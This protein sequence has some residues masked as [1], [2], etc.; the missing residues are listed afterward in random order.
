MYF[1]R[2]SHTVQLLLLLLA[3]AAPSGVATENVSISVSEPA[4]ILRPAYPVSAM[5]TLP[6]AAAEDSRFRL[7]DEDGSPI[8]AQFR[9]D[10]TRSSEHIFWLDFQTELKPYGSRKYT[11]QYGPDVEP[12]PERTSGHRLTETATEWRIENAPYLTWTIPR[13]LRSLIKSLSVPPVEFL[14][15]SS[16]GL[17]IVDRTGTPHPLADRTINTV[18]SRVVREGP[19]AV[20]LRFEITASTPALRGVR[21]TVDLHFPVS[22]SWVKVN[23]KLFDPNGMTKSQKVDLHLQLDRPSTDAPTL[24]DFGATTMVYTPLYPGHQAELH[25]TSTTGLRNRRS[26]SDSDEN[27]GQPTSRPRPRQRHHNQRPGPAWKVLRGPTD[28][29][30]PFFVGPWD[31]TKNAEGWAHAMDRRNCLALAISE[32]GR[33]TNDRISISAEGS[34]T[35]E[36]NAPGTS[37]S[38]NHVGA[39]QF[40]FW[41]HFVRFPPQQGAG[42]SPQAMQNPINVQVLYGR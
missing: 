12:G 31:G 9:S 5:F 10:R 7:V 16:P 35:L 39:K 36:R 26:E 34:V 24:V 14:Q 29:L 19:F 27:D 32:F 6:D 2:P 23:W 42:T 18:V 11:V 38:G 37:V 15:A 21:S 1:Q 22:R 25:A 13:D 33:R 4:G 17:T 3:I 40:R 30:K 28:E 41:L 8:A 20:A